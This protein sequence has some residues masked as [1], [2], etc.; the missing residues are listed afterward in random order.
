MTI[1]KT[2]ELA[3]P[4]LFAARRLHVTVHLRPMYR[5]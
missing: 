4:P 5:L 3:A 1:G 2:F